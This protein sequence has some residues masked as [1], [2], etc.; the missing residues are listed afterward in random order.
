MRPALNSLKGWEARN[1]VVAVSRVK[2]PEDCA[3][4]YTALTRL[5]RHTSGSK[6]TVVSSCFD[7]SDF[8]RNNFPD[9][10]FR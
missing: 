6:L 9:F 4:F 5:K 8:G 2:T 3:L 7:L 10:E 1:L